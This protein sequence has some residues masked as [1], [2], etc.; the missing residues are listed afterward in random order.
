MTKVPHKTTAVTWKFIVE[1]R[2]AYLMQDSDKVT[3]GQ[4]SVAH[5]TC[6]KY[7]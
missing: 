7:A 4:A 2:T 1:V 6:K 5:Q 3:K